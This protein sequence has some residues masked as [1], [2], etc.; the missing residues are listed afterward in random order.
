MRNIT[1]HRGA[2]SVVV[3]EDHIYKLLVEAPQKVD[4]TVELIPGVT[5]R[6]FRDMA[7]NFIVEVTRLGELF[8]IY[9]DM[10]PS[11]IVSAMFNAKEGH[12]YV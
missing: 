7:D 11:R 9:S 5:L 8:D 3:S 10:P 12:E 6:V 4:S 1:L 2:K